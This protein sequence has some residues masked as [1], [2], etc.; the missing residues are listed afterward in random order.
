MSSYR[1]AVE[2]PPAQR[3]VAEEATVQLLYTTLLKDQDAADA[4]CT[5]ASGS[6]RRI[7]SLQTVSGEGALLMGRGRDVCA[8]LR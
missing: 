2:K 7:A 1:A 3:N 8:L 5:P 4:S 6:L